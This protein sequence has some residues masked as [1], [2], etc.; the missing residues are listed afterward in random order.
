MPECLRKDERGWGAVRRWKE[1]ANAMLAPVFMRARGFAR[2][3]ISFS[4][5]D[6]RGMA[7]RKAQCP[8]FAGR[9]GD[10]PGSDASYGC[11]RV[12]R[13]AMRGNRSAFAFTAAGRYG[14]S[15]RSVGSGWPLGD[16]V[17]T[18]ARKYRIPFPSCGVPRRMPLA[19]N[20]VI[21]TYHEHHSGSRTLAFMI[22]RRRRPK[23]PFKN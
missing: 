1:K 11:A 22:G 3:P 19:W 8:D 6:A 12:S 7:R 21:R 4:S 13:R 14:A 5:P 2:L 15:P 20:Q 16:G 9:P 10:Q 18:P 23:F 17:T